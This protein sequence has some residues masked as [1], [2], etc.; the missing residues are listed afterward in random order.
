MLFGRLG[1]KSNTS[2]EVIIPRQKWILGLGWV[3][4]RQNPTL[5]SFFA[6]HLTTRQEAVLC[7]HTTPH[8]YWQVGATKLLS[9][10]TLF[11]CIML[12]F[13]KTITAD[14]T[15]PHRASLLPPCWVGFISQTSGIRSASRPKIFGG[16][17]T[18]AKDG[19]LGKYL[20]S[21]L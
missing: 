10:S 15:S 7:T 17:A 5:Q 6:F 19:V 9:S 14:C 16:A 11:K 12:N 2:S 1:G 13:I 18:K 20:W 4:D 8:L 21:T 3:E